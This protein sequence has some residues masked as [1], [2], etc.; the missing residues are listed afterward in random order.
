MADMSGRPN[1]AVPFIA[2][3]C[4]ATIDYGRDDRRRCQPDRQLRPPAREGGLCQDRFEPGMGNGGVAERI[5]AADF[6]CLAHTERDCP[7]RCCPA[8]LLRRQLSS[9]SRWCLLRCKG[10]PK[11]VSPT[12]SKGRKAMR[13]FIIEREL[14]A[15]GSAE[16]QAL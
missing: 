5:R 16:R 10:L 2:M 4:R 1:W 12:H 8:F 6:L 15:I 13:K 14:P 7:G 9:G 11:S 3:C